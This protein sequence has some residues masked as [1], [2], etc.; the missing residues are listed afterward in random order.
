[1][2]FFRNGL[3]QRL[4]RLI[5]RQE[6]DYRL[7]RH[8][9]KSGKELAEDENVLTLLVIRSEN[10]KQSHICVDCKLLNG[11]LVT[12]DG[13]VTLLLNRDRWDSFQISSKQVLCIHSPWYDKELQNVKLTLYIFLFNKRKSLETRHG[14]V[15]LGI[16][17]MRRL[18]P[19][20]INSVDSNTTDLPLRK[21]S[22]D[23]LATLQSFTCPCLTEGICINYLIQFV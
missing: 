15:I 21:F 7:W 10:R 19:T 8:Q 23:E 17:L 3:A 16:N 14:T 9:T 2:T 18:D 20:Q 1:M 5:T 22:E 12:K 11:K 4:R 13:E 6:S